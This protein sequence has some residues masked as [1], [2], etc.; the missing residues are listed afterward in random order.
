MSIRIDPQARILI[1]RADRIGDFV[2]STPVLKAVREKY[3]KAWIACLTFLENKDLITGNPYINEVILYDKKGSERGWLGNFFFAKKL[4]RKRFDLAIHL[5]AT[6]RMH[7]I[8]KIAKIPV[9][10]GWTRKAA[11]L[12]T[13]GFED[14]K[15]K[16]EKHE[17]QYNFDLLAPLGI[18]CP[19][20][21][22]THFP[23]QENARISLLKLLEHHGIS[24]H[25]PWIVLSPG[26]SCPSKRWPA[27]RFAYLAEKISRD[28]SAEI[29]IIGSNEDSQRVERMKRA[30]ETPLCDLTGKLSLAMLGALLEKSSLLVSNDSGPV[31]IA[32]A[33][34]TPVLSIFGRKQPGLSP[35]RWK[36]LGENSSFIWK[37][38]GCDP[39]LAH[40]CQI[41]F[42]CL[43]IISE[44]EVFQEAKKLLRQHPAGI[45]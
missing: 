39:C 14:V 36:P 38:A 20:K 24:E 10:I 29:I 8:T 12:L 9:R 5:H 30:A 43:D 22:E 21:L 34:G 25:K 3:P 16:G 1:T 2:L 27:E 40:D 17:A 13:H 35:A 18:Q 7:W 6:N 33:V 42:L 19:D 32:D 23:V 15:R 28:I 41:N 31:H 45:R 37:D 26:A 11:D 44:E 4:A